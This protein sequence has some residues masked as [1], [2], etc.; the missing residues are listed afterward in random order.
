MTTVQGAPSKY[1]LNLSVPAH[2]LNRPLKA[3]ELMFHGAVVIHVL[4]SGFEPS[5]S[6]GNR[7]EPPPA[8]ERELPLTKRLLKFRN[9]L[10][11]GLSLKLV[12]K[13]GLAVC[14]PCPC[15]WFPFLPGEGGG[16]T[17]PPFNGG[18]LLSWQN[19]L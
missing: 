19:L 10:E 9:M 18:V 16:S 6:K 7:P 17:G 1:S 2:S 14:C 4:L 3:K 12:E 11:K 5:T 13:H 8:L 15:Q